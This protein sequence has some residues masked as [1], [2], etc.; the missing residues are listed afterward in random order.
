MNER[1]AVVLGELNALSGCWV[2]FRDTLVAYT[3]QGS[4]TRTEG[5]KHWLS[6]GDAIE[7]LLYTINILS[8]P[9]TMDQTIVRQAFFWLDAER[10]TGMTSLKPPPSPRSGRVNFVDLGTGLE[11]A[12]V[13]LAHYLGK[14]S[15]TCYCL[16]SVRIDGKHLYICYEQSRKLMACINTRGELLEV[17]PFDDAEAAYHEL[18]WWKIAM[19]PSK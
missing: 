12:Q 15:E 14:P 7:G 11:F 13:W 9:R 3:E 5:L 18:D 19:E 16:H 1:D 2:S 10:L 4:I 8:F 6:I 17:L